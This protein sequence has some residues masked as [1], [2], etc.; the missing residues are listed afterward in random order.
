MVKKLDYKAICPTCPLG[1]D[2][3]SVSDRKSIRM[4]DWQQ[5]T[6]TLAKHFVRF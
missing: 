4:P 6:G 3:V 5:V 1:G 2:S